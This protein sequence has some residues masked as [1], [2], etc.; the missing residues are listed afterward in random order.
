MKVFLE[1]TNEHKEMEFN[2]TVKDLLKKLNINPE[3]V[4]V[5]RNN[6]LVTESDTLSK[7]DSVKI[8]S[9]ISGG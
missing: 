7:T 1:K 6:E 5:A 8:L 2:G 4:L 9:V 3:V